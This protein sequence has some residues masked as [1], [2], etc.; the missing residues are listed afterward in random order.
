MLTE[1][2]K[3]ELQQWVEQKQASFTASCPVCKGTG[4]VAHD[5]AGQGI[6]FIDVRCDTCDQ[7]S[8][9]RRVGELYR[10]NV[11]AEY[12]FATLRTLEPS[13]NSSLSLERQRKVIDRIKADPES[14][15]AFFGAPGIGKTVWTTALYGRALWKQETLEDIP[16]SRYY[17]VWR[18]TTKR[19]LDEHTVYATTNF[20]SELDRRISQ[21]TVTAQKIAYIRTH[22]GQ[23]PRLFL[24]EIDKVKETDSR[25]SNLFEILDALQAHGGQIVI[26]SN[27]HTEE[28]A[29]RFGADLWWRIQKMSAV[30]DLF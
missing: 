10:L 11:P 1:Q 20:E 16:R 25:R 19:M 24:E 30:I 22:Q 5:A 26:N 8:K 18:I 27:L 7:R 23:V 21:P 12:R 29:E 6:V 4:T 17:P 3:Q 9:L 14:G 15:Y 13:L 2:D 28:F